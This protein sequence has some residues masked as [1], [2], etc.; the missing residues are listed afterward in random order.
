MFKKL[1]IFLAALF[2]MLISCAGP[3]M[4]KAHAETVLT[5]DKIKAD[6][7]VTIKADYLNYLFADI[8]DDNIKA[9]S[10]STT[11]DTTDYSVVFENNDLVIT[12][13]NGNTDT[14]A[15][16][17]FVLNGRGEAVDHVTRCICIKIL[18]SFFDFFHFFIRDT[19]TFSSFFVFFHF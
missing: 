10:F 18:Q 4:I 7:G 3:I 14:L 16:Y 13:L 1:C 15:L 2:T 19:D 17:T 8:S 6:T 12:Y 5:I 11:R 9:L